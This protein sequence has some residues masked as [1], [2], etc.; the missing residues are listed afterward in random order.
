MNRNLKHSDWL[1]EQNIV[2]CIKEN[3]GIAKLH[4]S[5]Q[6]IVPFGFFSDC[7]AQDDR[8][9][10]WIQNIFE[11]VPHCYTY[12]HCS[13]EIPKPELNGINI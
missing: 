13:G 11:Q 2:D 5:P 7:G 1:V 4:A 8:Y 12:A 6:K 3:V 10:Y 9:C